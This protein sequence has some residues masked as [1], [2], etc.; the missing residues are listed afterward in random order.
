MALFLLVFLSEFYSCL[1][2]KLCKA[3]CYCGSD[4]CLPKLDLSKMS[5]SCGSAVP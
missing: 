4:D 2:I 5:G 3:T 1:C